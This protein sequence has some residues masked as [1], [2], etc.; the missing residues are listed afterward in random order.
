MHVGSDT[1]HAGCSGDNGDRS[2][3]NVCSAVALRPLV[4]PVRHPEPNSLYDSLP[5]EST[6]EGL[7]DFDLLNQG[8]PRFSGTA[9]DI[10][11]GEDIYFDTKDKQLT[12][13]HLRACAALLPAFSPVEVDGRL[14]GDAGLSANLPLDI[15]LDEPAERPLLCIALDLLPLKGPRPVSL[16]DAA[17]R[18][19]DLLFATQ[20]RR[21]IAAWQ[22]I[23][24]ERKPVSNSPSV[25]ILHLAY[26]DHSREVSGKA[27]DYSPESA[28]VRW[29]AGYLDL[30]AALDG[31]EAQMEEIGQAGLNVLALTK[32]DGSTRALEPVQCPIAPIKS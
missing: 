8:T 1:P 5:V 30:S 11:S 15:F 9:I 4:E 31:L 17:C 18:A 20:S 25:T 19:Q 21:A 26:S 3:G 6:L 24:R 28:S 32:L 14:V 12:P 16:G 2:A 22:A 7:I 23:F 27:F 29:E 13:R 10:E